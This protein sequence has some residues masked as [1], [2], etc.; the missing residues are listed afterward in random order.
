MN[1]LY[2]LK[3][4]AQLKDKIWGG[5]RMKNLGYE[6]GSLPNCGEAWLIS[7]VEGNE[8]IV[9]EGW[10]EGNSLPELMEIYME[11]LVGDTI[12]ERFGEHF[13]LLLKILDANDWLSIQVHPDDKMAQ[14]KGYP[15]GKT[16]IWY[17]MEAGENAELISGFRRNTSKEEFE[18]LLAEKRLDE[19]LNRVHVEK[20]DVFFTP[21]GRLHALG[22]DIMLAE[23]QQS[24]DLTYRV[25]DFDRPGLDGRMRELHLE[26]ALDA[27]DYSHT[28]NPKT[29]Y[30]QKLNTTQT[31]VQ[32]DCFTT[33]IIRFANPVTKDLSLL[34]S[35]V[36]YLCTEGNLIL[37]SGK[38][39]TLCKGE[40]ILVPA[41]LSTITL[42]PEKTAEVLE[43]YIG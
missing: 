21:A 42:I 6:T 9:S 38:S 23:I 16:E 1:D 26:D 18:R 39:Y 33:N 41:C 25:F 11:E 32:H 17:V 27:L 35:F 36:I 31:L 13:P 29:P 10:L 15:N 43:I 24:S 22:P 34:D 3:F 14:R 12:Y 19:I 7:G 30:G 28:S 5:Q 4:V 20:G 2:P 40:A 37:E 8:S